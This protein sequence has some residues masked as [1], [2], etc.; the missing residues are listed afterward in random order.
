MEMQKA[1]R[2]EEVY[3]V[4]KAT[5]LEID[6]LDFYVSVTEARGNL[7]PRHR[8][9]RLLQS[10][11]SN[12]GNQH[13]LFVGYKGCGKSTELNHLQKDIEKDYL[14]LS[15]S[16]FSELDP[17]H[18]NY[19]ELYII[20]MELL[21][22]TAFDNRLEIRPEYI[23]TI[24]HWLQTKEIE[25][26]REKYIGAEGE[27][28]ATVNIDIGWLAKFFAKFKMSSKTSNS[29]K[30]ILKKNIE[31]KLSELIFHCNTLITEIRNQL[32]KLGKR[33]LLLIIE[34]LDKIP[35][36]RASVLFFTH[37]NQLVLLKANI[38]FTFPIALYYHIKFRSIRSYFNEI[39]EL[40]MVKVREKNQ[41][42]S[43][44][45]ISGMTRIIEKRMN[46][47]LFENKALLRQLILDSGGCFRDLFLMIQEASQIALD[48][49]RNTM[50]ESDCRA[51]FTKLKREY[52]AS[53]ANSTIDGVKYTAAQYY[54][55]LVALAKNETK[56]P[57]NTNEVLHLRQN[58]CILG[59]NGE[60]WCDVHPIVLAILKE[61]NKL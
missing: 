14:S 31:P 53:I 48:G 40:P 44:A 9:A 28:S 39:F 32:D 17:M 6:D 12:Q 29:L 56:K 42:Y 52:D 34:D 5:P 55:T 51:A 57:E 22:K 15:F 8:I 16:V 18:L 24:T 38:I 3:Q 13:I 10:D 46:L 43:E 37:V 27:M 36:D 35:L 59:Y 20:T 41:D 21:F 11:K 25:E 19:I 4:F 50:S 33:D 2:L 47:G 30:E 60:G 54:A 45:G 49:S 23:E 58:L 26:I 7:E 61:R 1:E